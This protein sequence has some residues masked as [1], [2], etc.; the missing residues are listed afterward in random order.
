MKKQ[1]LINLVKYHVEKKDD[2]FITEVATIARAFDAKGDSEVAQY[3]MELISTANFY[4]PQA[5]YKNLNFLRKIKYSTNPLILPESIEEDV[6]GI[7]K[8][9]S[10][11]VGLS[12]F[13][14][15]GKPGTGK[16]ESAYQIARILERDILAV[17]FEQLIDS[18]LG[19]TAKNVAKLFDEINQTQFFWLGSN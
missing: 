16:T 8:A 9:I 15:Y 14:F 3:L 11:K 19:E 6:I 5:N 17:D 18:R 1:N 2:A 13:L 7:T 12:K 4:V 10:N